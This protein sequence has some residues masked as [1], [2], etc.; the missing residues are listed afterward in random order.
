MNWLNICAGAVIVLVTV[1]LAGILALNVLGDPY[2]EMCPCFGEWAPLDHRWQRFRGAYHILMAS[3]LG[4]PSTHD[5]QTPVG[6]LSATAAHLGTLI[7]WPFG[8]NRIRMPLDEIYFD[9][10]THNAETFGCARGRSHCVS[11]KIGDE[12][13]LWCAARAMRT[14]RVT[15]ASD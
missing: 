11:V 13:H 10:V 8:A 12:T 15:F 2:P 4:R 9:T 3:I 14:A 6:A 5:L 7:G 1:F